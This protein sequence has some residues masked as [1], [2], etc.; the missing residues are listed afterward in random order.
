MS[1]N[2]VF[3]GGRLPAQPTRP[4]LKLSTALTAALP[5]P[6]AS[7]DW[8]SPVPAGAWGVLG[9][10]LYGDCTC[11][12]VGHKRIGDVYVNQGQ[13]LTVTDD[14]ALALYSA[15]TGFDPNDP[16]TDQGAVCQDVLEYWQKHGFL[17]EKI[18]AFAKVDLTNLVEVRQAINLCGQI[19]AGFNFPG[20]AMDQ[21]NAGQPW[22]VVRGAR[23]EGGHC[24]TIGAY[25]ADG[26]ECV[27][28]GKTQRLTTAF[29]KRYFDEA[30]VILDSDFVNV[31]TGKDAQ[32]LNLYALGQDFAALTGKTNPIP[33]PAP[34]P[35]PTPTPAPT[36]TPTVLTAA[37]LGAKVRDLLTANGA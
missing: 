2:H 27:T 21:F 23:I 26:F 11:A 29:F 3:R 28:W 22:D 1:R 15:V 34:Q 24:V 35:Q 20:T 25:D 31:Q 10:D 12:G 17:G 19:Y 16:S 13:A 14:D 6:P 5:S 18:L 32:G 36:P 37:Q 4:H 30:W 7:S 9:N 33:A 8:L